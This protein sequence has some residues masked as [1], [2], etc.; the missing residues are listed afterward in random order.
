MKEAV[1]VISICLLGLGLYSGGAYVTW[2][3]I[4]R[5]KTSAEMEKKFCFFG[6]I[7]ATFFALFTNGLRFLLMPDVRWYELVGSVVFIGIVF[8]IN[9]YLVRFIERRNSDKVVEKK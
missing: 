5:G 2:L 8:A 7:A 4:L 3:A 6:G 1:I 9:Y